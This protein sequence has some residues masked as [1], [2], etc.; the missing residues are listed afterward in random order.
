MSDAGILKLTTNLQRITTPFDVIGDM[1][2][3]KTVLNV[4]AVG[5][6]EGYL[7]DSKEV[8]LHHRL[9]KAGREVVGIDI[10]TDSINYAA[11]YGY[12]IEPINCETMK[13]DTRFDLIVMSDVIEHVNAPVLAIEN[14]LSHL[15]PAGHLIITTPNG[16]AGNVALRSVFRRRVHVFNDHVAIYY[17]EHFQV[18]C[19][20][21]K[22][23]LEA[24]YMF[25][26][27]D[28]RCLETRVKSYL[29]KVLTGI[30]PRLAS[31]MMVIIAKT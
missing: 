11:R 10:D 21:L 22:C 4:G 1:A 24:I 7:P 26:H 25:D 30:S 12:I 27:I 9:C 13:I 20:R 14:L 31:S 23:C 6:I 8:W 19:N 2:E 29:F 5:G 28:K 3:G 17:P 18:I 16:T 15:M